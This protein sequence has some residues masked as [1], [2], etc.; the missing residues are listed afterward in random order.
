M[1][2]LCFARQVTCPDSQGREMTNLT[3]HASPTPVFTGST[4]REFDTVRDAPAVVVVQC[5]H[6]LVVPH[7]TIQ[8]HS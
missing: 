1:F 2:A 3:T 4:C 8:P 7:V 5:D 6:K